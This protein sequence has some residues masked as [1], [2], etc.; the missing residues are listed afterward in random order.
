MGKMSKVAKA[1]N[2]GD[3]NGWDPLPA[4][5]IEEMK[6]A[7]PD[8]PFTAGKPEYGYYDMR[9]DHFDILDTP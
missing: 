8:D 6:A 3:D 1:K 5:Q 2:P 4:E 9:G 7:Q